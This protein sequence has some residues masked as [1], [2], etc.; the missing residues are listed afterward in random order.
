MPIQEDD[1]NRTAG[2]R[3][4]FRRGG[5]PSGLPADRQSRARRRGGAEALAR[6]PG[7][8]LRPDVAFEHARGAGPVEELD[9]KC[10]RAAVEGLRGSD[11]PEGFKVF[12]NVEPGMSFA[13]LSERSTG[14]RLVAEITERALN[15]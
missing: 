14:P 8:G 13:A 6:W 5:D 12:V 7:L 10:Q 11:L 1:S 2:A 4:Y 15:A 3:P 9:T